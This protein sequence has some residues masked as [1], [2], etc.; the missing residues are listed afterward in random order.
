M[1]NEMMVAGSG[2]GGNCF[3]KE[4]TEMSTALGNLT[5]D[6]GFVP[7]YI[8]VIVGNF[9][10]GWSGVFTYDTDIGTNGQIQSMTNAKPP[11]D[12]TSVGRYYYFNSSSYGIG[13]VSGTTFTMTSPEAIGSTTYQNVKIFAK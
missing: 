13:G 2:G 1:F 11:V 3:Y 5:V 9:L 4:Y 10:S 6:V 12:S 7:S 8:V